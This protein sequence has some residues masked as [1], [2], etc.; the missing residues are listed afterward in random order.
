MVLKTA[1]ESDEE[2]DEECGGRREGKSTDISCLFDWGGSQRRK[3]RERET[4]ARDERMN[5]GPASETS[6]GGG[7]VSL[8][9]FLLF[10]RQRAL[11]IGNTHRTG[12]ALKNPNTR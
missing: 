8:I 2:E 6:K 10:Q 11:V 7:D 3:E 12:L 9:S 1:G 4:E 5:S